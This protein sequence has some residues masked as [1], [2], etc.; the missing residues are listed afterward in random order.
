MPPPNSFP[1]RRGTVSVT[2]NAVHFDESMLGYFR[3]LYSQYWQQDEWWRKGIFAG[4]V[5]A[6][7][8]G[9]GWVIS[10]IRRG[11]VFLSA[12]VVGLVIAL[13]LVNYVRGF[14]SPDRIPLSAITAVSATRGTKGLT[15]P[16]LVLTYRAGESTYKCRVNLPSLYTTAGESAYERAQSAFA[17][18]GF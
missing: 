2:Q 15:R 18:R 6:L 10:T 1:T 3:S 8:Y 12:F 16:R 13:W 14:R 7:V 5:F 11:D 4:Y 9:L 17:E